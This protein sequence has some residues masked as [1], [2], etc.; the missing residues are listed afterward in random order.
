MNI[1]EGKSTRITSYNYSANISIKHL[2]GEGTNNN[3]LKLLAQL[4]DSNSNTELMNNQE[5]LA[6]IIQLLLVFSVIS[7]GIRVD[8]SPGER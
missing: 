6:N 4:C 1:M 2:A 7:D 3:Y 5:N 8:W